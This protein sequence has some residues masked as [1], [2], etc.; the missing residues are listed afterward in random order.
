MVFAALTVFL[1]P[2]SLALSRKG[3]GDAIFRWAAGLQGIDVDP[4]Y[5]GRF[6]LPLRERARERGNLQRER[7]EHNNNQ[8][9]P[10][11]E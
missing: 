7:S 3:R 6:P 2:L 4:Q 1:L 9:H 11:I 10:Q 8:K 5:P